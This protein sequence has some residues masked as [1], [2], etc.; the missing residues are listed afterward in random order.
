MK[1][2]IQA[3]Y[4]V[5]GETLV[6]IVVEHEQYTFGADYMR[7]WHSRTCFFIMIIIILIIIIVIIIHYH[8]CKINMEPPIV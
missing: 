4:L 7:T 1:S 2:S 5:L 3:S 6:F 8:C